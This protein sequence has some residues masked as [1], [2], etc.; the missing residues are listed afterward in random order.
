MTMV[1][2]A[3]MLVSAVV[4]AYGWLATTG[5]EGLLWKASNLL[6]LPPIEIMFNRTA[7]V[8]GLVH[9]LLPYAM[10]MVL[11]SLDG[12]RPSVVRAA[13]N[14][15]AGPF[16]TFARVVL[17]LIR[18]GLLSSLLITFSLAAASYSIPVILGGGR[19]YP[20]ARAVFQEST[21]TLDFPLAA[22]L[23][24]LLLL[25]CLAAAAVAQRLTRDRRD[26]S[27]KTVTQKTAEK[28]AMG[29]V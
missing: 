18:T 25:L 22:T 27:R 20:I 21:S 16:T 26:R 28:M 19:L 29:P 6:G 7:V 8:I 24:I 14:L 17:P 11:T 2:I 4:R 15:G 23:A 10:L 5:R 9:V 3:P 12:I 13:A 1:V